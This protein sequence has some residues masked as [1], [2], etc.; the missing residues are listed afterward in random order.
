MPL[1][2]LGRNSSEASRVRTTPRLRSVNTGRRGGGGGGSGGVRAPAV[3]VSPSAAQIRSAGRFVWDGAKQQRKGRAEEFGR[4]HI[5]VGNVKTA[6][7]D[8]DTRRWSPGAQ[9]AS[10][11]A[12]APPTAANNPNETRAARAAR[13]FFFFSVVIFPPGYPGRRANASVMLPN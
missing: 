4:R 6:D 1:L 7:S 9:L 3:V 13:G 8:R 11:R 10:E 12:S 5:K 2:G